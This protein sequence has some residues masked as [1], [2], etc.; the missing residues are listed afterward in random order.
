MKQAT[1]DINNAMLAHIRDSQVGGDN[2]VYEAIDRVIDTG[3]WNLLAK[4]E[5][6]Q[7][8]ECRLYGESP[9]TDNSRPVID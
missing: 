2:E 1:I 9:V 3:R 8:I 7:Y 6:Q 5:V 4:Y